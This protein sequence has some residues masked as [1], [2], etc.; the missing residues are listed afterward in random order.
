MT[1]SGDL[2][3]MLPSEA[4][5]LAAARR[6]PV[7]RS[8]WH[9]RRAERALLSYERVGWLEDEPSRVLLRREVR[10]TGDQGPIVVCLDTSASMM[11]AREQV[12]KAVVLEW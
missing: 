12:A 3:A 1:R 7:F 10:P 4:A 9:A 8:L 5:L 2:E 11:G 6:R